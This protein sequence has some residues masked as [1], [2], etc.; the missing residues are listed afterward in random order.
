MP[1]RG[2]VLLGVGIAVMLAGCHGRP[3]RPLLDT[4]R[5]PADGTARGP[6]ERQGLPDS[7]LGRRVAG[8][9]QPYPFVL[10]PG[11]LETIGRA[12]ALRDPANWPSL[13]PCPTSEEEARDLA[14]RFSGYGNPAKANQPASAGLNLCLLFQAL[15]ARALK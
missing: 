14:R 6:G 1:R 5:P 15:L 3:L 4:R 10:G 9:E 11:Q 2:S 13:D 8:F 7:R 12:R